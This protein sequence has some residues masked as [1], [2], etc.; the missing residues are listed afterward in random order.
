MELRH[1]GGVA[2]TRFGLQPISLPGSR[3]ASQ[4]VNFALSVEHYH[5]LG[6]NGWEARSPSLPRSMR[7]L[8]SNES[9]SAM[10][11]SCC[12]DVPEQSAN[13]RKRVETGG[14]RR[15]GSSTGLLT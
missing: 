6:L 3:A 10:S 2:L 15:P 5:R 13:P 8:A 7:E 12:M 4:I 14:N 11:H 9:R 1:R